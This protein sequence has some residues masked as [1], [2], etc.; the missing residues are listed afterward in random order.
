MHIDFLASG[1][2]IGPG[3]ILLVLR[4][5]KFLIELLLQ[6][7]DHGLFDDAPLLVEILDYI[8]MILTVDIDN[9]GFDGG[10]TLDQ[11]ASDSPRH[12]GW[13]YGCVGERPGWWEGGKGEV[14][15]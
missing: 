7:S 11:D 4:M 5:P 14:L 13:I 12:C 3:P 1:A 6:L 15:L 10:V 9:N 8:V 2:L